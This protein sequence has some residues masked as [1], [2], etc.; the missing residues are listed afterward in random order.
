MEEKLS[1]NFWWDEK[2][3]ESR[4]LSCVWETFDPRI[5]RGG[6]PCSRR[7]LLQGTLI[8]DLII[9]FMYEQRP[10]HS[11]I[12]V[13]K[14]N[15]RLN[16]FN[17]GAAYLLTGRWTCVR[18]SLSL[19]LFLSLSLSLLPSSCFVISS[20]TENNNAALSRKE[21]ISF[22]ASGGRRECLL[23][24]LLIP[25]SLSLSLS[26]LSSPPLHPTEISKLSPGAERL[27]SGCRGIN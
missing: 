9:S 14:P 16:P 18:G 4:S 3:N 10:F 19:P 26:A 15:F 13:N 2:R 27:R 17:G 22:P 23:N 8:T 5:P 1:R 24:C 21:A 12:R 6:F 11:R 7:V 25:I 20:E